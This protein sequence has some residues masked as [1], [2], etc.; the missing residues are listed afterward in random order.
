MDIPQINIM[1]KFNAIA[2]RELIAWHTAHT[3]KNII[4]YIETI[5]IIPSAKMVQANTGA[6]EHSKR[7]HLKQSEL[8]KLKGVTLFQIVFF[9]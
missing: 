5:K 8:F 1:N 9:L 2:F 4:V 6:F 7:L 3:E